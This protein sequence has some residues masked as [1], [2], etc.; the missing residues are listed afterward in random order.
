MNSQCDPGTF[1]KMGTR[2]KNTFVI[3]LSTSSSISSSDATHPW[4]AFTK[5]TARSCG[6]NTTSDS[7][8]GAVAARR[9]NRRR[10]SAF[11]LLAGMPKIPAASSLRYLSRRAGSDPSC[12]M[13]M[14]IAS[15]STGA[16][17]A[18]QYDRLPANNYD[19]RR[20]ILFQL[21]SQKHPL[22]GFVP[23]GIA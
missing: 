23:S 21:A 12:V 1:C 10:P 14:T 22:V 4:H 20:T 18:R 5:F 11:A 16:F 2:W 17:S 6:K 9:R 13:E 19:D 8:S 7:G 3:S 15:E